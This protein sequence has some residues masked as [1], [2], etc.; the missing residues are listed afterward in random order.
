MAKLSA[1]P[2]T[3]TLWS[4]NEFFIAA[5]CPVR[6]GRQGAGHLLSARASCIPLPTLSYSGVA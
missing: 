1:D 3:V 4:V 2:D 5:V 6:L